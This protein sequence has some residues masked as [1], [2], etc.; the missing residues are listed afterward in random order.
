MPPGEGQ[1]NRFTGETNNRERWFCGRDP[2]RGGPCK[3]G[4]RPDG[5]CCL[6]LTPCSP[7]ASLR[8]R[9]GRA[10]IL[11]AAL[12]FAFVLILFAKR[13][14]SPD[15]PLNPGHLSA[16]HS[17]A[18]M[19]CASCHD[20]ADAEQGFLADF[21]SDRAFL[22]AHRCID[23]HKEIGGEGG[24]EMFNAH[25]LPQ[26]HLAKL[27]EKAQRRGSHSPTLMLTLASGLVGDAQRIACASCHK[28][29][30]GTKFDLKHLSNSQCQVCHSEQFDRF[31][32]GHPEFTSY[33]YLRRT[34]IFFDHDTH[35][36]EY[37]KTEEFKGYAKQACTDC[38]TEQPGG[39]M[40]LTG[41]FA[42][43]CAD[44]HDSNTEFGSWNI[45]SFPKVDS[46]RIEDQLG[47]E[48]MAK[49]DAFPSA[50]AREVS[51]LLRLLL[52]EE[53]IPALFPLRKATEE[54]KTHA[55]K[56][57]RTLLDGVFAS[58]S[59]TGLSEALDSSTL[60]EGADPQNARRL[61]NLGEIFA[62]LKATAKEEPIASKTDFGGSFSYDPG[63]GGFAYA[64][65]GHAGP[66]DE[67]GARCRG[68]QG[69]KTP[70]R[71]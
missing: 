69:R 48:T 58:D 33:P 50:N 30:Q 55:A 29:H 23:C 66:S 39:G 6:Q 32:H 60:L 20:K 63:S 54:E 49:L 37:L 18:G 24:A 9:R 42:K 4:P 61:R 43:T 28:E 35:F 36:R 11:L 2:A 13:P 40:M 21:H 59:E 26:S 15:H 17:T 10:A 14:E 1:D 34:R 46:R 41:S 56:I 45:L 64:P 38:H 3:D 68:E 16:A 70:T 25:T 57:T 8:R 5:S 27:T 22:D 71:P 51:P 31:S 65:G 12:S 47:A 7:A 44:C 19:T 53:Q 52:A 67:G 62:S